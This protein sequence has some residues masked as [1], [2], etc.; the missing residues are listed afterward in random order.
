MIKKILVAEDDPN[1]V[2]FFQRA[3]KKAGVDLPLQF[4][5]DGQ[6]AIDYLEGK[7]AFSDR[8]THP[9]PDIIFVDL[10]MP[11]M[12]GL[13]L[14]RRLRSERIT[15]P[16][17]LASGSVPATTQGLALDA[18]LTKPFFTQ[19]LLETV[20]SVLHAEPLLRR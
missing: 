16:V 17:I 19:Q 9:L 3:F 8:S 6:Y 14:I 10:N 5:A 15:V 11:R 4:V 20:K 7:D 18:I 12:S 13:D 1:D 2:F